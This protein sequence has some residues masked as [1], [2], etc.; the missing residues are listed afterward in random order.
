V[1]TDSLVFFRIWVEILCVRFTVEAVHAG[2]VTLRTACI[3]V[4]L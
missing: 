1:F 4:M 3:I 2:A